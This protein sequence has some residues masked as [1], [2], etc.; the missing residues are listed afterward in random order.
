M[1]INFYETGTGFL[2]VSVCLGSHIGM[3]KVAPGLLNSSRLNELVSRAKADLRTK[4]EAEVTSLEARVT[5]L[6]D[7]CELCR[8]EPTMESALESVG[9]DL[10]IRTMNNRIRSLMNDIERTL[11]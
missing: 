8:S 10:Q 11:D 6:Q 5:A 7:Q 9:I 2:A 4:L 3:A 1:K